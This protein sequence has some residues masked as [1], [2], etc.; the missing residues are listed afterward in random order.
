MS[1]SKLPHSLVSILLMDYAEDVYRSVN[2]PEAAKE[3]SDEESTAATRDRMHPCRLLS[4]VDTCLAVER[5]KG[6]V[7][8]GL[9][10]E[11]EKE[12]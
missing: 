9:E 1:H 6:E 12:E 4:F 5:D 10:E 11:E 7:T 3:P 2:T 8:G